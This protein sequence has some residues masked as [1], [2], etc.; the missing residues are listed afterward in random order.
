[1]NATDVTTRWSLSNIA[2]SKS[3]QAENIKT[4]VTYMALPRI[5]FAHAETKHNEIEQQREQ[6]DCTYNSEEYDM[7][8]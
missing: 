5:E 1:V 2:H 3:F 4:D 7:L 8:M 6:G